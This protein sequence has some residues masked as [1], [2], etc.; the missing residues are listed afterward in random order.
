MQRPAPYAGVAV[1]LR[2]VGLQAVASQV[3]DRFARPVRS[4]IGVEVELLALVRQDQLAQGLQA[5][6]AGRLGRRTQ[7]PFRP[8]V[9]VPIQ[10]LN[11]LSMA[12]VDATLPTSFRDRRSQADPGA[13]SA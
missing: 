11:G 2:D 8:I 13:Q 7:A 10:C 12:Q 4:A 3:I 5:P 9:Q 1:K 6:I